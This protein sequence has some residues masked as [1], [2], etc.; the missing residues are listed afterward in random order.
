MSKK[1]S[2]Q[3]TLPAVN[4]T[5]A[6]V[7]IANACADGFW[8][9]SQK[10]HKIERELATTKEGK[11]PFLARMG[12]AACAAADGPKGYD[13]LLALANW[14]AFVEAFTVRM[15][16]LDR[17]NR[18]QPDSDALPDARDLRKIDGSLMTFRS[19]VRKAIEAGHKVTATDSKNEL[20]EAAGNKGTGR[21]SQGPRVPAVSPEQAAQAA[22][23]AQRVATL[24]TMTPALRAVMDDI[25]K[26]VTRAS[27]EQQ[28]RLAACMVDALQTYRDWI[29]AANAAPVK[30]PELTDAQK[31][32]TKARPARKRA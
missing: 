32:A 5:S 15:V 23:Q 10:V 24:R 26:V 13:R 6:Q 11:F 2:D 8:G 28:D 21:G 1:Q 31:Q 17:Q 27:P 4:L 30:A 12:E 25:A 7:K 9:V 18:K 29:A 14:D 19:I 16:A 3:P 20:Q 22:E